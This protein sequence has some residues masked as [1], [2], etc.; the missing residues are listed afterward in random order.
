MMGI[1]PRP[2]T[3]ARMNRRP[4]KSNFGPGRGAEHR[5]GGAALNGNITNVADNLGT[6]FADISGR[7]RLRLLATI[8]KRKWS[9][10]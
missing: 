1:S 5:N 10:R 7:Q 6:T 8:K 3:A 4:H 2:K 9:P